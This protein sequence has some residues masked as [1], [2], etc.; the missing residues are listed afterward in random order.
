MV[1]VREVML[2]DV[3][4]LAKVHHRYF[5]PDF[6]DELLILYCYDPDCEDI[7]RVIIMAGFV[8]FTG[9][10]FAQL[11]HEGEFLCWLPL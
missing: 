8:Y 11:A 5:F 4:G 1:A 2:D 6:V 10:T 7:R 9:V 3:L